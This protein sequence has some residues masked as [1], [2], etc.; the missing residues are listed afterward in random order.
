MYITLRGT[1]KGESNGSISPEKSGRSG[2]ARIAPAVLGLGVVSLLTDIS[3]ESVAAILPLYI[4]VVIG[5]GPLAFGFI[6]G[7]YQGISAVVRMAGGRWAD[8]SDRGCGSFGVRHRR[9]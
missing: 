9:G 2:K 8:L 5:L 3:S 7:I 4:T 1:P 6:D